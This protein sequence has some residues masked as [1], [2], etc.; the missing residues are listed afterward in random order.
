MIRQ[1]KKSFFCVLLTLMMFSVSVLYGIDRDR[2]FRVDGEYGLWVEKIDD[3][4]VVHWMTMEADSGF[5]RVLRDSSEVGFFKT[6]ADYAH[7]AAFENPHDDNVTIE[8]GCVKYPGSA[9]RTRLYFS[10]MYKRQ[11][12]EFSD[13]DTVFVVGDVHGKYNNLISILQQGQVI[14][15][16]LNWNANRNHLV[17]MGDI[18]DRGH[19]VIKALWFLYDLERQARS[20][21]GKLSILLGN[22]EIMIF[23]HDTRYVS[24]KELLVARYHQAEYHE[25][26]DIHHSVLGNWLA[27]QLGLLK[28]DNLLFAHGGITFPYANITVDDLNKILYTYLHEDN[29]A[30]LLKR[31]MSTRNRCFSSAF[32]DAFNFFFDPRSIFWYRDFVLK[33]DNEA[34]LDLILKRYNARHLI[35]GHSRVEKI[36]SFYKTK[37]IAVDMCN[38]ASELLMVVRGAEKNNAFY[39]ITLDGDR[40]KLFDN[41][42][43]MLQTSTT[44]LSY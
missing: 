38:A 31:S 18:F 27:Q 37:V 5:L 21:G 39:R 11:P 8:Y 6:P 14:D 24:N 26:F 32:P 2:K 12:A 43:S 1:N 36:Q 16:S 41:R 22:H 20:A 7:M 19:N 10:E 9:Q 40:Q 23:T 17:I 25:M 29:F 3:E 44:S 13:V 30:A 33:D 34:D 15:A 42:T 35:V 4:V 28:I